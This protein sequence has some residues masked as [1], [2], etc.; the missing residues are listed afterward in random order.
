MT[1]QK[2]RFNSRNHSGHST[3]ALA[4]C[5]STINGFYSLFARIFHFF[6]QDH[7]I[8]A[9]HTVTVHLTIGTD[10]CNSSKSSNSKPPQTQSIS[11]VSANQKNFEGSAERNTTYTRTTQLSRLFLYSLKTQKYRIPFRATTV[12]KYP[13]NVSPIVNARRRTAPSIITQQTD[14]AQR[15]PNGVGRYLGEKCVYPL[16]SHPV[17]DPVNRK[18]H[19]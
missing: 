6:T 4:H 17:H 15:L 7:Q 9:S 13:P 16:H 14:F 10:S 11:K 2:F 19:G 3:L 1:I 12:R 8:P 18:C 5:P